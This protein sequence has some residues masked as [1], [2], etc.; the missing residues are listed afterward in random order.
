MCVCVCFA[1]KRLLVSYPIV[2]REIYR[3]GSLD[4]KPSFLC[5]RIWLVESF[6]RNLCLITQYGLTKY[7]RSRTHR[8]SWRHY[9]T[10]AGSFAS[11]IPKTEF[12]F[13]NDREQGRVLHLYQRLP[14]T[15][16]VSIASQIVR[17][18]IA[19]GYARPIFHAQTHAFS[20]I[21]N[22]HQS[23]LDAEEP[24]QDILWG[25]LPPCRLSQ[26]LC[27]WVVPTDQTRS[28]TLPRHCQK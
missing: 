19:C 17:H 14:L 27:R 13:F 7:C 22:T 12:R 9:S 16:R 21:K 8:C 24:R 28:I 6:S 18:R 5:S 4:L 26:D 15:F 11:C 10:A 3:A 25:F 23:I 20:C 1:Q 2:G